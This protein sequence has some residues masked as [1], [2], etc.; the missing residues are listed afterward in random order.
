MP[1]ALVAGSYAI[2]VG[3]LLAPVVVAVP[4]ALQ[5]MGLATVII[6]ISSVNAAIRNRK[7]LSDG[8]E[9]EERDVIGRDQAYRFPL[10]A[11][12]ALL[13]M[14]LAFKYLPKEWVSFLL[15]LYGVTFGGLALSQVLGSLISQIPGF[16]E[17]MKKEIGHKDYVSF[18][19]SDIIGLIPAS[20]IAYWYYTTKNWLPNNILACAL[21]LSAIDLLAIPAFQVAAV[22]LSGLFFYDVFWVFGSK[23][24]FGSNVMVSVAK[25]FEG[26]IKLVFPRFVGAGPEDCSMLG[27]GDIV[28]PGLFVALMLRFDIRNVSVTSPIP[29]LLPY[30]FGAVASYVGGLIATYVALTVFEAAQPALLYL[31]P[32]NLL[33]AIILAV[34]RKEFSQ[35]LAYTEEEAV[36][37]KPVKAGTKGT[38]IDVPSTAETSV[39]EKKDQ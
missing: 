7:R 15:T 32:A 8:D 29:S 17:A 36:D 1:T 6:V 18:T 30:F 10:V 4:I 16:P 5:M 2:L 39:E 14:F 23:S 13:G 19:G 34:V 22:L 33:T 35:L 37:E 25:Q 27:L 9:A 3:L 31:V 20:P 38:T 12:G 28:I 24:V 21:G 26:P 11:S